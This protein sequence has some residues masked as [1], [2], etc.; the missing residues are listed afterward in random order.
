MGAR[1]QDE[2]GAAPRA[3]DEEVEAA[4]RASAVRRRA[5]DGLLPVVVLV[6]ALGR[7]EAITRWKL[8]AIVSRPAST[9]ELICSMGA[10]S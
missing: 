7:D 4:A 1:S 8:E 5:R 6:V 10:S 3:R 2:S 9:A